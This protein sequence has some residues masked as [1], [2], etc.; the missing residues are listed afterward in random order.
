[1]RAKV[2]DGEGERKDWDLMDAN[3]KREQREEHGRYL[4]R[5]MCRVLAGCSVLALSSE[6][7][8]RR[9]VWMWTVL[10]EIMEDRERL[11]RSR[12]RPGEGNRIG[13]GCGARAGPGSYY[14]L[15]HTAGNASEPSYGKK[16]IT[17]LGEN[18]A[19]FAP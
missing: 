4:L 17:A 7:E 13:D 3:L 11:K 9:E 1:M 19:L 8:K 12:G 10:E 5:E 2:A 14:R 18:M 16:R 15:R 6:S